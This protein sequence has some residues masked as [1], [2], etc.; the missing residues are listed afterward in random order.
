[1][2]SSLN[3][4]PKSIP[5]IGAQGFV[6]ERIG[7]GE[8]SMSL[9]PRADQLNSFG[10]VHGGVVMTMLDVAMA[11]AARSG[12]MDEGH[13]NVRGAVTVEMKT[14]F[15]APCPAV[16]KLM[17]HGMLLKR[18]ATLAFTEARV[19]DEAGNLCAH[20]TGTF[21]LVRGV[22]TNSRE[23]SPFSGSGSD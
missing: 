22:A 14:S 9:V 20:A 10:V 19:E 3:I 11:L 4:L 21:K 16:G 7:G 5:F 18:T 23:I 15:M 2:S 6:F 17:A 1:M 12:D 13:V 8:S